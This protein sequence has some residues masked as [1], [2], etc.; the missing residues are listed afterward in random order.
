MRNAIMPRPVQAAGERVVGS[1]KYHLAI[2]GS[3]LTG[4]NDGL[5]IGSAS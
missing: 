3:G 5:K 4:I 1:D 2:N